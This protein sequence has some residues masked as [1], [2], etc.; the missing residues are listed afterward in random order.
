ME[1]Y[2]SKKGWVTILDNNKYDV[3]PESIQQLSDALGAL[4]E[5]EFVDILSEVDPVTWTENRRVLKGKPF[6]FEKRDY[7]LQPYRDDYPNLI[8]MKGRQ[9]EMSEFSM[10]WLLRK[11]DK[12]PYTVG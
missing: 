11:L 1:P 6:S 2:K 4:S 3:T 7:L 8:F 12:Y 10:N 5:D 9:V